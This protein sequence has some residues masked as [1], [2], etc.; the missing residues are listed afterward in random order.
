MAEPGTATPR[1]ARRRMGVAAAVVTATF[2][3]GCSLGPTPDS[4]PVSGPSLAPAVPMGYVVCP[5]AVTP[6]ELSSRTPEAPISLPVAGAPTLGNTA[7]TV[8]PDGRWAY[9]VLGSPESSG[10]VRNE[11]VPVDLEVQ[12]AGRPIA[13]PGTG[14]TRGVVVTED[15]RTV[16][17]ASGTTVVPVD[18]ATR[19]VGTPLDLGQGNT[20]AGLVRATSGPLVYALVPRGVIPIDTTTAQAKQVITTGLQVSSLTSPHGITAAPGGAVLYVAGQGGTDFGGRV[21]PVTTATGSVGSSASFDRFG[22]A[23]P[24]AVAVTSDGGRIL[25]VDSADNWITTVPVA[26]PGSGVLEGPA[27]PV[28]LP[29]ARPGEPATG[30]PSDIITGPEGTGNFLVTGFD[31]VLP[32]D[33]DTEKFGRP[34][35]VCSGATSMAVAP[36]R[37][38]GA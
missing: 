9:V 3:A 4:A 35:A 36:S 31:A 34:M 27:D 38:P 28:R 15:G 10:L 16:L 12:R 13:L 26:D 23:A 6:I 18:R 24:A 21:V 2:C 25:V 8:S 37:T 17:A 11:L 19:A 5:T 29:V 20:V 30:H 33:P 22:I 14:P 1:R 7:I 32:Y